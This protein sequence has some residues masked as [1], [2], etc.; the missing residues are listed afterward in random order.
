MIHHSIPMV[1]AI[2]IQIIPFFSP[3]F[4]TINHDLPRTNDDVTSASNIGGE[5][6]MA[7][8]PATGLLRSAAPC[9]GD[10]LRETGRLEHRP[11]P[12]GGGTMG[13]MGTHGGWGLDMVGWSQFIHEFR[14][15]DPLVSS[16]TGKSPM[17]I[18]VLMGKSLRSG[19]FS[20]KPC[21]IRVP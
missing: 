17:K 7:Q 6:P 5:S 16:N 12:V 11:E 8:P 15:G 3:L 9:S 4:T 13:T 14:G 2:L 20:G 1:I 10:G 19:P 21:L 18:E